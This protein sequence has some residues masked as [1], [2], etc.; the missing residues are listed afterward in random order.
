MFEPLRP[1]LASLKGVGASPAVV[2]LAAG[3]GSRFSG[4]GHKLAQSLGGTSVLATTLAQVVASGLPL[5]V[6]TTAALAPV[7]PGW[8]QC[9]I[10]PA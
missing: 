7:A 8:R 10:A 1:G 6:V 5:V 4:A 2:V 9:R 3:L